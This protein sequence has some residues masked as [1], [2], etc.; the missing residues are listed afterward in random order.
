[1]VYIAITIK[2]Y[3]EPQQVSTKKRVNRFACIASIDTLDLLREYC[4][5]DL[6][7]LYLE[8]R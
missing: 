7:F 2:F 8:E 6:Y 3:H 5:F 4:L 1:M